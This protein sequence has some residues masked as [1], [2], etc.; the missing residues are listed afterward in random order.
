MKLR[1]IYALSMLITLSIN[2]NLLNGEEPNT[3]NQSTTQQPSTH[4]GLKGI[5]HR[6]YKAASIPISQGLEMANALRGYRANNVKN[7]I[8]S[9]P[10]DHTF[11]PDELVRHMN[12]MTPHDPNAAGDSIDNPLSSKNFIDYTRRNNLQHIYNQFKNHKND[13][14]NQYNSKRGSFKRFYEQADLF[15]PSHYKECIDQKRTDGNCENIYQQMKENNPQK[16]AIMRP[17]LQKGVTYD[18]C[19]SKWQAKVDELREQMNKAA[20]SQVHLQQH[21]DKYLK[22]LKQAINKQKRQA[23]KQSQNS[24]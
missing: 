12:R 16:Y 7:R 14:N 22:N 18:A 10:A 21:R 24:R 19:N 20:E 8:D 11:A 4:K 3:A 2:Y 17:C 15:E 5:F 9:K 23:R 1:K 6:A 13:L